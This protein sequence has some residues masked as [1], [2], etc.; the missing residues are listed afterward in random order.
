MKYFELNASLTFF[1]YFDVSY[2]YDFDFHLN[3]TDLQILSFISMY[4]ICLI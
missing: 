4:F 1:Y 2:L 3:F